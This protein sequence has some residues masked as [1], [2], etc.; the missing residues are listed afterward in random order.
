MKGREG[1]NNQER[2]TAAR[3]DML[4]SS[5]SNTYA[6]PGCLLRLGASL[7]LEPITAAIVTLDTKTNGR[8]TSTVGKAGV[9]TL[10]SGHRALR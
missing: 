2:T 4:T 9:G 7:G 8:S 5:S 10:E 6:G 1:P 3:P